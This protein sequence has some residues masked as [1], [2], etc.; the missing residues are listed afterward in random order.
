MSG[1]TSA[2]LATVAVVGTAY[3]I[4]SGERASSAQKNAQEKAQQQAQ[5]QAQK[6]E[7]AA[8]QAIN[9]ANQKKPDTSAVL[10]SA[11]QAGKSGQSGTMLTGPRGVDPTSLT[12][13]KSTLLGQ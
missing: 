7:Q 8:G 11:Q 4:Y 2:I 5:Q 9:Q 3:S 10:S 1:A 12:L 6:Q 13:G